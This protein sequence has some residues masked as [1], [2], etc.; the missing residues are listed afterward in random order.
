MPTTLVPADERD[1]RATI[2]ATIAFES[3]VY[4]LEFSGYRH[5]SAHSSL[6]PSPSLKGPRMCPV[7]LQAAG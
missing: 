2:R 5:A 3:A 6:D 4:M 7:L 1:V